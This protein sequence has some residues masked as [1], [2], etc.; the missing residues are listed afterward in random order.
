MR[1]R[2]SRRGFLLA[3]GVHMGR[4][5]HAQGAVPRVGCQANGFDLKPGDFPALLRALGSM[6]ELGYTGFECNVRFVRGQFDRTPEARRQMEQTGVRFIG[7]HMSMLEARPDVYPKLLEGVAALGAECIV[8]S[9][10]GLSPEGKFTPEALREK[11]AKLEALAKPCRE[12]GLRLAYHNH[13]P[14]FANHNAEIEGLAN[15]TSA[16]LVDFLIDAGHGYLGGGNPA[17]FL[18]LHSR[19]IVGCHIKTF[20]GKE[21][22]VPLGQGDFDF[23]DLASAVRKAGWAGWLIDEEGGGP[24][25][26]DT[27]ALGPDREYIRRVFGV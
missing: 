20:R 17:E 11:A 22:Q 18:A 4:M 21:A 12:K 23:R 14:E 15:A 24:T 7:A 10:A 9:G 5:A 19:R 25:P 26:G 6:K 27:A 8:M 13:N 1:F 3:A 2:V 16:E